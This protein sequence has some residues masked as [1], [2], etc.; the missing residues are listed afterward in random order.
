MRWVCLIGCALLGSVMVISGLLVPAHLRAVDADVL[1][2]AERKNRSLVEDGLTLVGLKRVG[3]AELVW[4]TAEA[5]GLPGREKLAAELSKFAAA[6][7]TVQFWGGPDARLEGLFGRQAARPP[8]APEP[9]TEFVVQRENREK[10]LEALRTSRRAEVQ[11]LL[12]CRALTNTLLFPPVASAAGQALESALVMAALLFEEG[13]LTP[14]MQTGLAGLA[15]EANRGGNSERFEQALLDLVS[16][17]ERFNWGQLTAFVWTMETPETLRLLAH[18]ARQSEGRLPTLFSATMVSAKPGAVAD[19]LMKFSRTGLKDVG[20]SL[21]FGM[22]G[23]TELLKRG[24][25]LCHPRWRAY[26][27]EFNPFYSFYDYVL[28][29]CWL[30]PWF[31]LGLKWAAYL[32]GGFLVAAALHFARAVPAMEV[33]LHVRGFHIAREF[34]FA[35]GFLLVV[36]LLSEP[37]LSQESQKVEFPFRVRLPM[38]SSPLPAGSTPAHSSLMDQLSLLTLVLFF[39]LQALLY[40]ACLV[41]LAEVRRQNLPPRIKLK[42]LD[43]ED[44]LFDA[45]LYLGFVGTIISLILVSLG[46]I[47]PSLMAA[48]SSTS[49]GIIFVSIFKIFNLRPMRRELLLKAEGQPSEPAVAAAAAHP[50]LPS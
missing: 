39:V 26:V 32:A 17:G 40:T 30:M 46:V 44:H 4:R 21:R 1:K 3:A 2:R 12:K 33:P 27:V 5:E 34:L 6:Y 45:G 29:Y 8:T 43:N 14:G 49:F 25:S 35:L 9:F 22:G 20:H 15:A 37:F 38:V 13:W 23:L 28:D 50:T 16:L 47:K 19:Y 11:E 10:L 48:Y 24:Q 42:L 41:R 18:Q 31:A 7:P 36:I